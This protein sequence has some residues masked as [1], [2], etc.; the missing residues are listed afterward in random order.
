[1]LGELLTEKY[2]FKAIDTFFKDKNDE[3]KLG[4]IKHMA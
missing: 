2:L 3:I 1:M 4:I